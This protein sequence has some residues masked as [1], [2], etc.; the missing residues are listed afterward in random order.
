[1]NG[2]I[3]RK[4]AHMSEKWCTCTKIYKEDSLYPVILQHAPKRYIKIAD[5]ILI[6]L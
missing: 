5:P 3:V 6:F 4:K 2:A 1:M